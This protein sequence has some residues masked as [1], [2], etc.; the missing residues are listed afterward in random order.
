MN[1]KTKRDKTKRDR[2][3]DC[4]VKTVLSDVFC[5]STLFLIFW[6]ITQKKKKKNKKWKLKTKEINVAVKSITVSIR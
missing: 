3:F 2:G 1:T 5:S 4:T 6:E